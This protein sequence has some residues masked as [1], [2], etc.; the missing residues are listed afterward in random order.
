MNGHLKKHCHGTCNVLP[1]LVRNLKVH[2]SNL[3]HQYNALSHE[4]GPRGRVRHMKLSTEFLQALHEGGYSS[5]SL[6][7]TVFPRY[8]VNGVLYQVLKN[9]KQL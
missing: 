8:K 7:Y 4:D 5:P 9:P 1:Q 6:I 2:Q 3:N